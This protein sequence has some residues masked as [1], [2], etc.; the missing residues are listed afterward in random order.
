MKRRPCWVTAIMQARE[1]VEGDGDRMI[2][3]TF[4]VPQRQHAVIKRMAAHHNTSMS[5]L[6]ARIVTESLT[7]RRTA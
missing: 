1:L 6:V 7:G 4:S 3:I 5:R 2:P